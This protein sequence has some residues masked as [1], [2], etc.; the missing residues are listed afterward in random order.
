[1]RLR[2]Q[3]AEMM[4]YRWIERIE[5]FR[6]IAKEWDDALIESGNHN[7][8]LLSDF[9]LT[10]WKYYHEN[11]ALRV[12]IAR[13]DGAMVG[14]LPLYLRR[15][16]ARYGFARVLRYVGGVAANYTEP[17]YRNRDV[18]IWSAIQG[19]LSERSDW[20]ALE[21][22]DIRA[23]S[24]ILAEYSQAPSR[25]DLIG[26]VWQDHANWA[27]DLSDGLDAYL[28]TI[29]KKLKRDLRSRRRRVEARFGPLALRQITGPGEIGQHFDLYLRYS[30]EAFR[31]RGR[32]S[33]F[34][35]SRQA[36]FFREFLVLMDGQGRLDAHALL[37]GEHV[38]AISVGY[39]L[40]SGFHWALT[41]FNYGYR[42]YRPGYLLI[43]ELL[44]VIT[45]RCETYYNWYGYDRFYKRQWCNRTTPLFRVALVRPTL[46]GY[47]YL[48]ARR[49]EFALRSNRFVRSAYELLRPWTQAGHEESRDREPDL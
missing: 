11:L 42:D 25:H 15:E 27:I 1:M 4:D 21:L 6:S 8:F 30:R 38:L 10:W 2:G 20:D 32:Q 43:E 37:A 44:R 29:S 45:D 22:S 33:S 34:E 19:A 36:M 39:R 3:C 47:A 14:G 9:I 40:G 35:D 31:S 13:Q 23:D 7:P 48:M 28:A 12:V 46:S 49:A 16:S 41:A 26:Q 17:L 24:R 5:E 18:G